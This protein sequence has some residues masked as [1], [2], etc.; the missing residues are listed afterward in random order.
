MNEINNIVPDMWGPSGWKFM[1]YITFAYPDSPTDE[2]KE[3]MKNFFISVSKVLPCKKCRNNFKKH[4]E[5]YPLTEEILESRYNLTRWLIDIH[6]EVNIMNGKK[7]VTY[8]EALE[9]YLKNN[10]TIVSF[11][12]ALIIVI[13]II[14][15]F[16]FVV[17]NYL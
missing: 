3:N 6:N 7:T 8:E 5:K 16:S 17:F 10:N 14:V 4:T 15:I 11:N 9:I 2:D 13:F 1:H 12:T